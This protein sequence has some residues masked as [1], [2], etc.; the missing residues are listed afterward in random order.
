MGRVARE[1]VRSALERCACAPSRAR[2]SSRRGGRA[3][4][5]R[6]RTEQI[7]NVLGVALQ[8]PLELDATGQGHVLSTDRPA[9]DVRRGREPLAARRGRTLITRSALAL[10]WGLLCFSRLTRNACTFSHCS[11][12]WCVIS[13]A[14]P[15]VMR[16]EIDALRHR[17]GS[18]AALTRDFCHE[19]SG[20]RRRVI[21]R[22]LGELGRREEVH[23]ERCRE[24][25]FPLARSHTPDCVAAARRGGNDCRRKDFR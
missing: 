3:A 20:G 15:Q 21:A 6:R 7:L 22:R 24:C 4:P 1:R 19:V 8:R 9:R 23:L 25:L 18:A 11:G 10:T 5:P 16:C 2:V 13:G 17:A 12:A 14:H